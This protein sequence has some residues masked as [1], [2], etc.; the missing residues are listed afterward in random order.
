MVTLS[1]RTEL[2]LATLCCPA[3]RNQVFT[4]ANSL[5]PPNSLYGYDVI[6]EV[7]RLR[8]LENKQIIEIRDHFKGR[9]LNIPARTVQWLCDRFLRFITVVHRESLPSI[10]QVIKARGGYVLHIDGSGRRGPMVL[11]LRDGWS[12]IR[13][14]TTHIQSESAE[15]VI[16]CLVSLKKRLGNPVAII[17][18]MSDG[19]AAAVE[20][21]FPDVYVIICHFHFLKNVGMRL[22]EPL[23]P[24]FRNKV[25]S[26]GV[27]KRLGILNGI[28]RRKGMK[29]EDEALASEIVEH[30]LNF[31]K[32]AKGLAY[33]FSL[34]AVNFYRRCTEAAKWVRKAILE[35]AKGLLHSPQ[36][37]RLEN[38]LRL[39]MPPP[40]VLGRLR[41]DFEDLERRWVWFQRVRRALRYRN[42]PIPLSTQSRLSDGDLEKG[43]LKLD[44]ILQKIEMLENETCMDR[45]DRKLRRSLRRVAETIVEHRD[46]LFAPNV[47][48][49]VNGRKVVR[50]LPRTNQPEETDFRE[51]RRHGRRIRGNSDVEPQFQRDGP[52]LLIAQNLRHREYVRL[53]YG[54]L[55]QMAARFVKI[56]EDGQT[57]EKASTG[58]LEGVFEGHNRPLPQ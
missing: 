15:R 25:D 36:L 34:P 23:Y 35:R 33:P 28:L 51:A 48:V 41:A 20:Q 3:H 39:L 10:S 40:I 11:L 26:R 13:L 37:S 1:G 58:G 17:M 22:F 12:G 27:K 56:H 4:P 43:R 53:V 24:R 6:T 30:I 50:K 8:T 14:L 32:D 46:E 21:V 54:S 31:K 47:I 16:P 19:L 44:W 52:G 5:V 57:V 55:G 2:T 38:I 9:G 7:G 45:H 49:N 18:D 29:T 42:G